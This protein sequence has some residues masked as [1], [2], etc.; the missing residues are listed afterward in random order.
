[1]SII[2]TDKVSGNRSTPSLNSND[3]TSERKAHNT[4]GNTLRRAGS[5]VK[6][7]MRFAQ[8]VIEAFDANNDRSFFMGYEPEISERPVIRI[9]KEGFDA[10][11]TSNENLIFNSEQNVFKIAKSGTATLA[12]LTIN[13]GG[14]SWGASAGSNAL[15]IPHG[16]GYVPAILAYWDT[17][18]EYSSLPV[19]RNIQASGS[20]FLMYSILAFVDATNITLSSEL[21]GYNVNTSFGSVNIKYYLLQESAAA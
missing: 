2:D 5:A 15:V 18:G 8:G 19:T 4:Y 10:K 21:T 17:G 12:A 11:T 14:A 6:Q 1:M 7:F 3:G 16:L 20:S 9:S 13:T